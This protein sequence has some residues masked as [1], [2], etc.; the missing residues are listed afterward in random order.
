MI[1]KKFFLLFALVALVA[2]L[3]NCKKNSGADPNASTLPVLQG[4]Y[5]SYYF[6]HYYPFCQ[7]PAHSYEFDNT[8][9]AT[10]CL[11]KDTCPQANPNQS[12]DYGCS[13]AK[14]WVKADTFYLQLDDAPNGAGKHHFRL[15][16]QDTFILDGNRWYYK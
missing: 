13:Q 5:S 11:Y 2:A 3:M 7:S 12:L 1:M 10:V 15:V 14:W 9:V 8:N 6:A 4:K 16:A